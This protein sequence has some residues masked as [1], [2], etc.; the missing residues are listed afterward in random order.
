[1]FE[2]EGIICSVVNRFPTQERQNT[3][4]ST[5][6]LKTSQPLTNLSK[7][8]DSIKSDNVKYVSYN[9]FE[10]QEIEKLNALIVKITNREIIAI[11]KNNNLISLFSNFFA[12]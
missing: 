12:H 11:D 1:M 6:V 2:N 3:F 8:N 7:K 10:G 4:S 5:A 9:L